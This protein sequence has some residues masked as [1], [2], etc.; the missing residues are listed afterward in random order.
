MLR[1]FRD[2]IVNCNVRACRNVSFW[3]P[4]PCKLHDEKSSNF[5]PIATLIVQGIKYLLAYLRGLQIAS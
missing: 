3:L 4:V 2:S 1:K 5:V